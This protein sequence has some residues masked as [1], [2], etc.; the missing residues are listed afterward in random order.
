M[1]VGTAPTLDAAPS[2][3]SGRTLAVAPS[4]YQALRSPGRPL[5]AD[6]RAS[7]EPR[8]GRDLGTAR[9][10]TGGDA[11][12]SAREMGAR[13]YTVGNDV[14]FGQGEYSPQTPEGQRLLAHEAT[15]VAQQGGE[16]TAAPFRA[17]RLRA[18]W[19]AQRP[20]RAAGRGVGRA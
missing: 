10:H 13:A 18:R 7:M 6:T 14:V 1:G 9:V 11:A 12:Q 3:Q 2:S 19:R 8:V 5:D 17:A 20:G 16:V 15:H 4:V